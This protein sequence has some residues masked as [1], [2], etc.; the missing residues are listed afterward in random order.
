[1]NNTQFNIMDLQAKV[2]T[3]YA[4]VVG[5]K[6]LQEMLGIGRNLAYNL[7]KQNKIEHIKINNRIFIPKQNV[8]KFLFESE[9]K[10]ER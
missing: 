9:V 4:D 1:M 6:E 7:I 2:F 8:I 5:I 3:K 10:N